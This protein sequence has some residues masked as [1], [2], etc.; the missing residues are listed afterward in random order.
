MNLS[1]EHRQDILG[2]LFVLLSEQEEVLCEIT[3]PSAGQEY[4]LRSKRI[5][6]LL[7]EIE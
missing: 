1:A 7:G 3:K 4:D 6:D 5:N 2:E